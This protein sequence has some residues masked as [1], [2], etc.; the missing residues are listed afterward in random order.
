MATTVEVQEEEV[1]LWTIDF[2]VL[3]GV[4]EFAASKR[5]PTECVVNH[6][7]TFTIFSCPG[8]ACIGNGLA[9]VDLFFF[10]ISIL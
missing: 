7:C 1:T 8:S 4:S 9:H 2:Q 3:L 6:I 10:L 5:L